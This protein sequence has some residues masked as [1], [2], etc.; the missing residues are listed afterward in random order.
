[1]V[2]VVSRE[3]LAGLRVALP[4]L[5]SDDAIA[6]ALKTAGA[7]VD[8]FALTQT[9]PIESEQ[10]E[11]MRQRLASGY[12]AWVVLSSWRAA[13]A[14]LAQLNALAL[15][16]ASAPTRLAV[17]G[18]STAEWVNSHCALKPTLVGAGSAAKLLEV[19][20]TP[21]TATTAAA[22][23]AATPTICLPQ[24][25]LAAPTLAQGLSQLGWQVDAVAT[26]TTVPLPQLPAHL[27]T[28]WQAGAWDAVVVTAG[29]SAQALLQL[30]GPPPEKTAVVSIGQSTTARCRELGLR[31]DATAATPRAE[32]ITQAIINLFKA[33]DFS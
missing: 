30:L 28:Q 19:F 6:A 4:R 2:M 27:K 33:K 23:T 25:Q 24:S 31:V 13:Q 9:I 26:Y 11:Q 8:T 18:Q 3:T 7:Q 15:A 20:P 14:V 10:L 22:S 5:K 32:H 29:S 17:V 1:M 21:P 12:Y 16:P